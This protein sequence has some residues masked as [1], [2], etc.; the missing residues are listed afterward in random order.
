LHQPVRGVHFVPN[1]RLRIF[2]LD[3]INFE[4]LLFQFDP[5]LGADAIGSG[6]FLRITGR[7]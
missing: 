2:T 7:E 3:F 5:K 4:R 1:N 6:K